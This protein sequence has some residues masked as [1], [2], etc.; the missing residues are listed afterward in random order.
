MNLGAGR[1]VRQD[2]VRINESISAGE[3]P[4]LDEFKKLSRSDKKWN[5]RLHLMGLTQ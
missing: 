2:L 3:L 5:K 1:P 4:N